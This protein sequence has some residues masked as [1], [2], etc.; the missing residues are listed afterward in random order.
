LG[1]LH[2]IEQ[3]Y[4]FLQLERKDRDFLL[5]AIFHFAKRLSKEKEIREKMITDQDTLT[6]INEDDLASNDP[7]KGVFKHRR[8]TLAAPVKP[9]KSIAKPTEKPTEKSIETGQLSQSS[10]GLFNIFYI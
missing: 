9:I 3:L 8:G 5:E 2:T 6:G 10:Q 1:Y 4:H 7:F